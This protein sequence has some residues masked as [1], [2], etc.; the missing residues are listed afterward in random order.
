MVKLDSSLE[1]RKHLLLGSKAMTNLDSRLK[2]K[3]ITL[4]IKVH[5]VKAMFFPVVM[6]GCE[7]WTIKMSECQRIDV[8]KLWC[9]RLLRVPWTARRSNKSIP[10]EINPK[11]SLV[12]FMLTL[13]LK[14]CGH[15]VRRADLLEK[16]LDAGKDWGQGEKGVTEDEIVR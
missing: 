8:C 15:L 4:L 12:G 5:I 9:S 6:Y 11:Y 13:K 10:K 3:D 7:S 1:I 14:Y 16:D 2:S